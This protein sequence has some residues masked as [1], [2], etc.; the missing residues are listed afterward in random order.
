MQKKIYDNGREHLKVVTEAWTQ[1]D[2]FCSHYPLMDRKMFFTEE[3]YNTSM[4]EVLKYK[5]DISKAES[6]FLSSS[7][8][9][10]KMDYMANKMK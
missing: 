8:F 2:R 4:D 9:K 3:N 5:D 1:S 7:S 6:Y 10:I